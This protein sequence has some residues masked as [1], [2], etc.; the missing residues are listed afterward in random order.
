MLSMGEVLNRGD[1][2]RRS[3]GIYANGT[4]AVARQSRCGYRFQVLRSDDGK[5]T[6]VE[7]VEETIEVDWSQYVRARRQG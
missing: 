2:A 3:S 6:A 4:L 7:T 1:C 5:G